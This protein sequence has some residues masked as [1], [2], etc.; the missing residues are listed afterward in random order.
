MPKRT[1]L[2]KW[3][4]AKLNAIREGMSRTQF[5]FTRSPELTALRIMRMATVPYRRQGGRD[6]FNRYQRLHLDRWEYERLQRHPGAHH[7]PLVK[8]V[9]AY[10]AL[11]RE[12]YGEAEDD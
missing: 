11:L 7:P 6:P 9:A 3:A 2:R 1:P 5:V 8:V 4:D 12:W 10:H